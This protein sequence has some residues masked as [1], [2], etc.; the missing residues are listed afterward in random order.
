MPLEPLHTNPA[1]PAAC[2]ST[3]ELGRDVRRQEHG[4]CGRGARLDPRRSVDASSRHASGDRA[5]RPR[6][7]AL[8]RSGRASSKP[9]ASPTTSMPSTCSEAR[10][11]CASRTKVWSSTRKTRTRPSVPFSSPIPGPPPTRAFRRRPARPMPKRAPIVSARWRMFCETLA[12]RPPAEARHA[13][14]RRRRPRGRAR[15]RARCSGRVCVSRRRAARRCDTLRKRSPRAR[16][17]SRAGSAHSLSTRARPR[18]SSARADRLQEILEAA[19]RSSCASPPGGMPSRMLRTL[20]AHVRTPS[21]SLSSACSR[22]GFAARELATRER[23]PEAHALAACSTPCRASSSAAWRA[24]ARV[25]DALPPSA[26]P[27]VA[28]RAISSTSVQK[29]AIAIENVTSQQD[30]RRAAHGVA[31]V[32]RR[33]R[34]ARNRR[35]R[36]PRRRRG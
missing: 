6:V 7:A 36:R 13:S 29:L 28:A 8:R 32:A 22:S 16:P 27:P 2:A 30:P 10:R 14:S 31:S 11:G 5:R 1:T 18:A 34:A 25:P 9:L 33:G 12:R 24:A 4:A 20:S 17:R 26:A 21:S 23:G 35:A 3:H 15:R 19:R